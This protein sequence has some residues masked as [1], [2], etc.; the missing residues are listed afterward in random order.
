MV[1][2]AV[3]LSLLFVEREHVCEQCEASELQTLLLLTALLVMRLFELTWQLFSSPEN[4][5]QRHHCRAQC[6][7]NQIQI[8]DTSLSSWSEES[9]S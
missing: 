4:P 6:E 5:K 8:E 7:I 1:L 9:M 2:L 3:V